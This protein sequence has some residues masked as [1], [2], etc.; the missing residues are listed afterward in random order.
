MG[1]IRH[2]RADAARRTV[3]GRCSGVELRSTWPE[4][5][6]A[7]SALNSYDTS[8]GWVSDL[9]LTSTRRRHGWAR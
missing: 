3:L 1:C 7:R 9:G 2:V 4:Q 5:E 8:D 6:P